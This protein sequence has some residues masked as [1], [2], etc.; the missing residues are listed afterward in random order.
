LPTNC[1]GHAYKVADYG[2]FEPAGSSKA[3]K[4]QVPAHLQQGQQ[5]LT[6]S[7]TLRVSFHVP[8]ELLQ[9]SIAVVEELALQEALD[10]ADPADQAKGK[11]QPKVKVNSQVGASPAQGPSECIT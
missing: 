7:Y 5:V 1:I 9:S 3:S 6:S 11:A 10:A 4:R 8:C 2:S